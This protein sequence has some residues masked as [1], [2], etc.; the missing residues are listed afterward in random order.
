V[1][2]F[3]GNTPSGNFLRKKI[4]KGNFYRKKIHPPRV[5]PSDNFN[6]TENFPFW[7]VIALVDTKMNLRETFHEH[8]NTK[9]ESL[10][11]DNVEDG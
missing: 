6:P 8:F 2:F 11:F 10:K 3:S 7:E 1:N 5:N 9:L 4:P